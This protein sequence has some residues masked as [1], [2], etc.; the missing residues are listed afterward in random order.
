[1]AA[2]YSAFTQGGDGD[3]TAHLVINGQHSFPIKPQ[4]VDMESISE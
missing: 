4:E 1:M 2:F 3:W